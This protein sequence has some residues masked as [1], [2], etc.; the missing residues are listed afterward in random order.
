MKT[1]TPSWL[2]LMI[3]NSR[4]HW[5][6][7]LHSTLRQ[8]WDT[9]HLSPQ[10]IGSLFIPDAFDEPIPTAV[11][12]LLPLL[13]SE[14]PLR[15]ASVVPSQTALWQSYSQGQILELGQVPIPGLYPSLGIDRALALLGASKTLGFPVLVIDA[16]TA[17]T[18]T[19]MDEQKHFF[20]GA[21]VAGLQTQLRSLTQNTA[22]LPSVDAPIATL[23]W[24]WAMNT[25]DSI[26]SGTIYTLLASI[27]DYGEA[28]LAR[29]PR[30]A[31][32]L[33]GGD[34]EILLQHLQTQ[35]PALAAQ[36]TVDPNLIFGEC[37]LFT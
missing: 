6:E 27:R 34:R 19:A 32:A 14:A 13:R 30:G 31:I 37:K 4:L 20:G 35:F 9:A 8:T 10:A 21:I 24:R 15:I 7:F 11:H 17:L 26:Q 1:A 2:A 18:F 36:I 23:P 28:W 5:A 25:P 16:G 22:A 33:T 29:F 3:G 12:D